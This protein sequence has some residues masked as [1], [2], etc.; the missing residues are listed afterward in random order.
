VLAWCIDIQQV[1]N[2][3]LTWAQLAIRLLD[4]PSKPPHL[5]WL[6]FR[7]HQYVEQSQPLEH[8][9]PVQ[10]PPVLVLLVLLVLPVLLL[11]LLPPLVVLGLTS[12][13]CSSFLIRQQ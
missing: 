1:E 6:L 2:N 7:L 5:R 12:C 9:L 3:Q 4:H 13:S 10:I 8:V 11:L